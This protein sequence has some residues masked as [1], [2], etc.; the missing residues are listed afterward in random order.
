MV[1]SASGKNAAATPPVTRRMPASTGRLPANVEAA[2]M[3]VNATIANAI[4]RIGPT[5]SASGPHASWQ[6][7]YGIRY[8]VIAM[9]AAGTDTSRSAAMSGR[10]VTIVRPSSMIT[11][12]SSQSSRGRGTR[13]C[14]EP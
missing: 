9:P 5:R 1:A 8:A 3:Q 13:G 12:D 7:P 14:R 4:T 2:T 10:I 6:T 11:N